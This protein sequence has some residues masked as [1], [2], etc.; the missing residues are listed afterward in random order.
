M[1]VDP[2]D[3]ASNLAENASQ[4]FKTASEHQD[5]AHR[6]VQTA[7]E[8]GASAWETTEKASGQAGEVAGEA[9]ERGERAAHELMRR[10]EAQ[11]LTSTRRNSRSRRA[12]ARHRSESAA[13]TAVKAR[14]LR[15]APMTDRRTPRGSMIGA[16]LNTLPDLLAD[17]LDVVFIGINPSLYSA[18][19]G[20]YF[21]RPSNRF[22]PCFSRSMLSGRAREGLG[23]AQLTPEHDHV[24]L[25]YGFG[26]TDLVK[27]PTVRASD[28]TVD[29]FE[30]GVAS[31][32]AMIER[33]RPR[34]ACFHG[35]TGYRRVHQAIAASDPSP[36]LGLQPA[37]IFRTRLFVVPSPSGAN[38]HVSRAEQIHWYDRLAEC[39]VASAR[40]GA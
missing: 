21:A 30:S 2:A 33:R 3:H 13:P 34:M 22:W 29:E 15:G 31:V 11:P 36:V 16:A 14:A 1:A 12:P 5:M 37:R 7:Q 23:I 28:L 39:M 4:S 35:I 19:R 18:A 24:L 8:T 27:R 6:A 17:E 10:A 25:R 20:H 38:A 9:Y 26:F 40:C 32:R